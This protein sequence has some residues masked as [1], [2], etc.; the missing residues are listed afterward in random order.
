MGNN[1]CIGCLEIRLGRK[2]S[3][4]LSSSTASMTALRARDG[5]KRPVFYMG[6]VVGY[7]QEYIDSLLKFLLE[8]KRPAIYRA[9]NINVMPPDGRDGVFEIGGKNRNHNK[10]RRPEP[11]VGLFG[12]YRGKFKIPH[13]MSGELRMSAFRAAS[14]PDESPAV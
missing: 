6:Q 1:L 8:A 13:S 14:G 3:L 7:V 2:I 5:V 4:V 10:R 12:G 9:R 11:H